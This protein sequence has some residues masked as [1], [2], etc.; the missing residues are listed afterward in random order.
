MK[1]EERWIKN[2]FTRDVRRFIERSAIMED[3]LV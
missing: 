2:E 3:R 1:F